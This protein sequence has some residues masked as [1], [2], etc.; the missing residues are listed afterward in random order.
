MMTPDTRQDKAFLTLSLGPV[1]PFIAAARTVRDLWSGSYLLSWLAF[2]AARP[3]R[4]AGG[5]FVFPAL[6]GNPLLA[7]ERGQRPKVAEMLAPC[8]PNRFTAIIAADKAEELA[9]NCE[10]SFRRAWKD[11][12]DKVY[13]L[14]TRLVEEKGV[15][16]S[17]GWAQLWNDQVDSF[18]EVRSTVLPW[19]ACDAATL[20]R[21]LE[22]Q[23]AAA[24]ADDPLYPQRMDLL[25]R[26]AEARR[27]VRH[28]PP[29]SPEG[30]VPQKCTILGTYEQ[31]GPAILKESRDF[32]KDF[33]AK[34][35][36]R[37]T[38]TRPNERLCAVSLV[39]R[40]SWAACFADEL[41]LEAKALRFDDTATEAARLWLGDKNDPE[42]I[43]P[44]K[45]RKDTGDW[46]GQWLHWTRP[47]QAKDEAP[48]PP[49]VWEAIQRRKR[50]HPEPVP[51]YYALLV[52]DGDDMGKWL[53]G[54]KGVALGRD[55]HQCLSRALTHFA[56]AEAPRA[57]EENHHGTLIYAGGDDVLALLPTRVALACARDLEQRYR[58]NWKKQVPTPDGRTGTVSAGLAIV[59][60]KED[61]RF[62]LSA[63]R[64]A[65]NAAKDAGKD[66]LGVRVCRRSGEHTS[67]VLPWGL[68]PQ[69]EKL[70]VAFAGGISDRWA[71]RLRGELP[72]LAGELVPQGAFR[73]ETRRLLLRIE[74]EKKRKEQFC[75]DVLAFLDDLSSRRSTRCEVDFLNLCQTAA[76]L[77]RG[78]D[79]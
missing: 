5:Q 50:R 47:D 55:L 74:A 64:G 29:Y 39:K 12:C 76:F 70:V 28:L 15:V 9:A 4:D 1:Q 73:A 19:A 31:L 59:H 8:L 53:R 79:E 16:H 35:H 68:A 3:V 38:H 45:I 51:T 48:V 33:A 40:F 77:A 21:L 32:W 57:V 52:M 14:L 66:R 37:G 67:A 22:A 56:L 44:D 30:D 17:R 49:A 62:A 46:S 72:T 25:G 10:E 24:G 41:K 63:A 78:R 6:E 27:S 42:R 23:P 71:Y 60:A 65:E 43:Q 26:L 20:D 58:E 75:S 34:V 11:V 13:Q 7:L 61:L 36:Y 18:W 69:L 54:E 2:Q